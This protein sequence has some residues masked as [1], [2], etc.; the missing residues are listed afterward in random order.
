M[1]QISQAA[2]SAITKEVKDLI[3]AGVKPFV[4][5]SMGIG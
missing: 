3:N 5:L 2:I 4:R 1:V